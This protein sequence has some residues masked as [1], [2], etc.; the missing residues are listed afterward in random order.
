VST[1]AGPAD[2]LFVGGDVVTMDSSRSHA[3][4]V[5]VRDGRIVAVGP[6]IDLRSLAGSSTRRVDLAGRTLVPGF[7]D[8]H[9][10][11]VGGGLARL[12]CDLS[13][14]TELDRYV[15]IIRDYAASHPELPWITGDGWA[16]ATFPGGVPRRQLLDELIPDRPAFLV[17]R[18]HHGAWVNSKA[19]AIAGITAATPDPVDG[20]IERD[21]TGEPVGTLQEGAMALVARHIPEPSAAEL[22]AG[23]VEAQRY[24]HG[25][26]ITGWQDAIVG[27][28]DGLQDNFDTYRAAAESGGLTARVVGALWWDRRLGSEQLELF[29]ERR[30][31]AGNGHFRCT[32]VKIM[33]DG[34]CENLTAAVLEPYCGHRDDQGGGRGI[35]FVDPRR[36]PEYVGE[37]A[38]AGFQVHF[39]AIGERG[40]REALDALEAAGP[41]GA[42]RDLRHHIAH[43]QVIHPDDLPRFQR[44]GVA[45]NMQP[46]WAANDPQMTELTI[47]VLGPE[48]AR[49]QYP[50]A[51]LSRLGT[52][53]CSGSDWPVS[54][55]NPLLAAH[56]AVNRLPP[57][58]GS[59][60]D[61]R[62]V[63]PFLPS[64][65]LDLATQLAAATI[66]S[67]YVNHSDDVTGSIEVG[68]LADL[69]LLDRDLFGEPASAIGS[70]RVVLTLVG[71]DV[72]HADG[73]QVSW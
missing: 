32:A 62:P 73:A 71:G 68:K 69:A 16:L 4:A 6:E 55:P 72:V 11:A 8:S 27:S 64:E 12:R 45:A 57:P 44:L 54:S 47:P 34:I 10:H 26:G 15:G 20:R 35:S 53:M 39:H 40:V 70:A 43:I 46:L 61:D 18:D 31:H 41:A 24:L 51:T 33:Q 66:G 63:A 67:A 7:Q 14:V 3:E 48:R 17:N 1:V 42:G 58:D 30:G 36:L 49:W 2:W 28:Y 59:R 37:L 5:A 38:T 56:V 21:S 19:L 23:L 22:H 29:R 65:S 9:I 25:F 13:E 50:F 52:A 60:G